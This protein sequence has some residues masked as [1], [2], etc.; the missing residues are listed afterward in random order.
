MLPPRLI[1]IGCFNRAGVARILARLGGHRIS[2]LLQVEKHG[3]VCGRGA[4]L[5]QAEEQALE[6]SHSFGVGICGDETAGIG[7][8]GFREEAT[9]QLDFLF[10]GGFAEVQAVV[11]ATWSQQGVV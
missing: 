6:F 4:S 9:V 2:P 3:F 5:L 10:A 7:E 1:R 8:R 11:D